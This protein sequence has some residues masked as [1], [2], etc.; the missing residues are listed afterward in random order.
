MR[1]PARAVAGNRLWTHDGAVWAV[2]RVELPSYPFLSDDAKLSLHGR[3][4]AALTTL[5]RHAQLIGVHRRVGAREL[6]EALSGGVR[7]DRLPRWR[8]AAGPDARALLARGPVERRVYLAA[9]I[10]D[11]H[12]RTLVESAM[13]L[14]GDVLG[15]EGPGPSRIDDRTSRR[16]AEELGARLA[17]TIGVR[18]AHSAELRWLHQRAFLRGVA[19]PAP[20]AAGHPTTDPVPRPLAGSLGDAVLHEG[21]TAHDPGRGRHRRYLRI[22]NEQGTSFQTTLVVSEMPPA[23][24]YPGG[25]EWFAVADLAPFPVDWV[26][27]LDA[28]PNAAA[29]T[30]ARRQQRQLTAQVAEYDGEP[31]G[32]PDTLAEALHGIRD[33]QSALAASPG[34]PELEVTIGFTVWGDDVAQVDAR[35]SQLGDPIHDERYV[36]RLVD[37]S[38]ERDRSKIGTIGFHQETIGGRFARYF[39][40]I[41]GILEGHYTGDPNMK[42]ELQETLSPFP[43][44]RETMNDASQTGPFAKFFVQQFFG[45]TAMHND[46]EVVHSSE[47]Q[48][49]SQAG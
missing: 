46:W 47:L 22:D 26:A 5:P 17:R 3:V 18:P 14:V 48:V 1:L 24:A 49:G 25:G 30:R 4:R 31:T 35:A 8:D 12:G 15:V 29:Q 27:R 10:V 6:G 37:F 23:F 33:E 38:S 2:W 28:V 16:R 34:D 40:D 42:A 21:G 11:P 39:L 19:D 41:V 32:P 44:S 36:L 13:A 45:L 7:P 43:G 20:P 9:R